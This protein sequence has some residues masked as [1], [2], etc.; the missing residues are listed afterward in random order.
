MKRF[1]AVTIFAAAVTAAQADTT[2]ERD[3]P[4]AGDATVYGGDISDPV[5]PSPTDAKIFF[6]LT[7][8]AAQRLFMLM[9]RAAEKSEACSEPEVTVRRRGDIMCMH[10]KQGF[11]C[12]LAFDIVRGKSIAASSC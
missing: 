4:L 11:A 10:D 5:A 12:Y 7:G 8:K 1:A 9:G 6:N 2:A 3:I